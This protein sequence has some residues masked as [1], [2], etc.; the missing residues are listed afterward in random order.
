M[1]SDRQNFEVRSGGQFEVDYTSDSN[2]GTTLTNENVLN[3]QTLE[4]KHIDGIT[5]EMENVVYTVDNRIQ[6]DFLAAWIIL[7]RPGS[8]QQLGQ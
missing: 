4:R 3:F 1:N 7:L 8:N 5:M 6:N 2:N